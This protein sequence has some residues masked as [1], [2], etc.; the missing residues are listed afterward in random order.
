VDVKTACLGVLTMGDATG[1]EIRKQFEDGP[2]SIFVEGGYGSIYPALNRLTEE[3]CV[4]CATESQDKRPDRKVYS[5]TGK[6]KL[7]LVDRLGAM[8]GP[9]KFRSDFLFTLFFAEHLSA[10]WVET[11]VDARIAECRAKLDQ[12]RQC[13]HETQASAGHAFVHDFGVAY[14]EMALRFLEENKHVVVAATLRGETMVA[15]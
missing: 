5:I 10:R 4:T 13:S 12:M 1:Y 8:P 2:F 6:G 9:D 11:V 14:Y 7:A 3:G 15:E